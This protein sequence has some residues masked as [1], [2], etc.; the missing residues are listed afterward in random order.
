MLFPQCFV[1]EDELAL[2]VIFV[3]FLY[4][5]AVVL[6]LGLELFDKGSGL[7]ILVV[8][9]Y[10]DFLGVVVFPEEFNQL[11][12]YFL[13]GLCVFEGDDS[14][15]DGFV[16]CVLVLS[17]GNDVGHFILLGVHLQDITIAKAND[18]SKD[19]FLSSLHS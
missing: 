15:L 18:R 17:K 1:G 8:E 9:T 19:V 2:D 5:R 16:L 3:L 14:D 7:L 11:Q 10:D 6:K 12:Y 13:E 4:D